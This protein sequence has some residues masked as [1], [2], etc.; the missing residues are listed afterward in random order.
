MKASVTTILQSLWS[1]LA[2]RAGFEPAKRFWRLHTFQACLF[3][4]S[5]TS[6][7]EKSFLE[8]IEKGKRNFL[9]CECKDS[10]FH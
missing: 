5:S 10:T 7:V 4:H 2:E 8:R 3:N 9:V 6:P 1:L